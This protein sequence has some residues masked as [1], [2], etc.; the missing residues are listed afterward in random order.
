MI[1]V[2]CP[3]H[4]TRNALNIHLLNAKQNSICA[5]TIIEWE[6]LN[7]GLGKAESLSVLKTNTFK[8]KCHNPKRLKFITR[9]RLGL[10]HSREH[11]FKYSFQNIINPSCS[12]CLHIESTGRFLPQCSQL[13][14]ERNTL[15]RAIPNIKYKLLESTDSFFTKLLLFGNKSFN[16]TDNTKILNATINFIL[17]TIRFNEPLF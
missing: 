3:L 7:P 10:N 13:V 2:R 6:K 16:I 8:F 12:C 17:L 11:K 15:L 4:S 9:F 1:L 14:N 5:S